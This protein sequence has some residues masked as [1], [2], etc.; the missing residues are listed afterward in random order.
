NIALTANAGS[1]KTFVLSKRFLEI[2]LTENIPLRKI[3]AITF[4]EKAAAE[5]YQRIAGQVEKMIASSDDEQLTGKLKKIRRSLV[6]VNI[7]T[8]H[9]FCINLLRE[10]PVEAELDANF[11][12]VD[13]TISDEL[14][15][16]A[17][18]EVIKASLSSD[19]DS[20]KTKSLIRLFS[21]RGI[22]AKELIG[23]AA[24]RKNILE[25]KNRIY[26]KSEDEI[27]AFF[28]DVYIKITG[29]YLEKKFPRFIS[30]LN[31]FIN[32][33]QETDPGNK[34]IVEII[35]LVNKLSIESDNK[36]RIDLL[37]NL[38]LKICTKEGNI[39]KCFAKKFRYDTDE[40]IRI[41][42]FL[43]DSSYFSYEEDHL[44]AEKELARTGKELIYFFDKI[45]E[46]YDEKKLIKGYIDFED[47]LLHTRKLLTY[48]NI[49]KSVW[50]KFDYIMIDE[51][52]DTNEI[53]YEIF[54]PIL[55]YLKRGNLFVVGDEKQSIYMFRDAELEVFDKTKKLINETASG[56]LLVLPDSFRMIPEICLFTNYIFRN[57][58]SE[59]DIL[60]NEVAHSELVCARPDPV[61][62]EIQFLLE[63]DGGLSEAELV[64]RKILEL[65]REKN[66]SWNRIA[67]LTRKRKSFDEL[68]ES[69]IIN[70]IPYLVMGGRN[71]YQR[72]SIYDIYNYFSFLLDNNNDGACRNSPFTI[73]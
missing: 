73:L 35:P 11:T 58:F 67:V 7:S 40:Q 28:F 60:F 14:M 62:G 45:I 66:I 70:K 54:L 72:Q 71:F 22:F 53:Q 5:L 34:N 65:R 27:A 16:M 43:T 42:E 3:A 64:S 48:E 59:P 49:R 21:S 47:I 12:P 29:E 37:K 32:Y 41:A 26:N 23:L 19:E 38:A 1:G 68:E 52:Q 69:F 10:Y 39:R 24:N 51:Y 61:K 18:E 8:I 20:H 33:I 2:A 56:K 63:E 6:S 36:N 57:L 50:Q 17:A 46:K 25:L 44:E 15:E 13:T 55:D 4:T 31:I 30:D 9:S